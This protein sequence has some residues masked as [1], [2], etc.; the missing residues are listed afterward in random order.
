ML[1][2]PYSTPYSAVSTPLTHQSPPLS[3]CVCKQTTTRT[4]QRF[5]ARKQ[6]SFD[7][8]IRAAQHIMN[9]WNADDIGHE[10]HS[11][12][13]SAP[14]TIGRASRLGASGA[15]GG[16]AREP[17]RLGEEVSTVF[18]VPLRQWA[19]PQV[20]GQARGGPSHGRVLCQISGTRASL[21]RGVV[22]RK[23]KHNRRRRGWGWGGN[24]SGTERRRRGR[25]E[26]R[27][28]EGVDVAR[29]DSHVPSF[30][31]VS[32]RGVPA[33]RRGGEGDVHL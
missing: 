7:I 30:A 1:T 19:L 33:V 10:T 4:A 20:M 29:G 2:H 27:S 5:K 14:C 13:L 12:F 16:V 31:S 9:E 18:G 3:G 15:A 6:P 23:N 17:A 11:L 26:P 24:C 28:G 22:R 25:G 8:C 21:T 32:I